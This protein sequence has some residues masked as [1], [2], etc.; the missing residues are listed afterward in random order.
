VTEPVSK[1]WSQWRADTDL[2]EYFHRWSR[3]ESAG[4]AA[5]GEADFIESLG[6]K[7]V[8]DAGCG[9]GRVAVELAGRGMDVVGVDLDDDLLAYARRQ[10]PEMRW[11]H[12]DL[13][14]MQL[15]RRF[16]VVAM[17]GNVMIF[18]ERSDRRSII[19]RVA[20]HLEPGGHLVAGF[21]IEEGPDALTLAEYD[22]YCAAASLRLVQRLATW[23]MQAYAGE[24]YAV[25]VHRHV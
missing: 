8:L 3:L 23:D 13:A 12:A 5:H 16:D 17:P 20:A 18:C 9:M 25:S 4:R 14:T 21:T 24:D 10:A 2:D 15:D 19:E 22:L 1:R 11:E 7:S 6:P